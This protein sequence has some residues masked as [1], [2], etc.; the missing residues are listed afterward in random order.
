MVDKQPSSLDRI[1][2]A[3]GYSWQGFK[4]AYQGE[5]AFREE[6]YVACVLIPLACFLEVSSVERILMIGSIIL[7]MIVE[8]LNSAIE[9]TVDRISSDHHELS[10]QAK[11][12]GSTAV[13]F[14]IAIVIMTWGITLL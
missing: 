13:L 9:T 11:D 6:V 2:K 1:I 7:L 12:M 3:G 4:R 8:L 10:G 14:A 5:A